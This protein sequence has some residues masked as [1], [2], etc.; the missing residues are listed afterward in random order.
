M[1]SL[2]LQLEFSRWAGLV[3]GLDGPH[4]GRFL[5]EAPV[6]PLAAVGHQFPAIVN[7]LPVPLPSAL[8]VPVSL[9]L[10]GPRLLLVG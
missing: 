1:K 9:N 3:R 8:L 4:E 10:D 6:D 5:D 7:N 2:A